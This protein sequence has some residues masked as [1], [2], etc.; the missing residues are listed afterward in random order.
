M[1]DLV[2]HEMIPQSFKMADSA[3]TESVK[4]VDLTC[5]NKSVKQYFVITTAQSCS[6]C[7]IA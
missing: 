1:L 2:G 3:S 5:Q 4:W 7:K 6:K